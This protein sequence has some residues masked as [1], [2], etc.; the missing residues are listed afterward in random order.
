MTSLGE[1]T[2][3]SSVSHALGHLFV[4]TVCWEVS[5]PVFARAYTISACLVT[6][7]CLCVSVLCGHGHIPTVLYLRAPLG[8]RVYTCLSV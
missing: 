4:H 1:H 7:R 2:E 8:T 5:L 3:R 6:P